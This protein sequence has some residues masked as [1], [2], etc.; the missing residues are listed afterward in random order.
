MSPFDPSTENQTQTS[1]TEKQCPRVVVV[2]ATRASGEQSGGK[3]RQE[4]GTVMERNP[5]GVK[6]CIKAQVH[7]VGQQKVSMEPHNVMDNHDG[8]LEYKNQTSFEKIQHYDLDRD[9]ADGSDYT[10][11]INHGRK[12]WERQ[13]DDRKGGGEGK[14]FEVLTGQHTC[15]S[16]PQI[17]ACAHFHHL[18]GSDLH[19]TIGKGISNMAFTVCLTSAPWACTSHS[20][21][22]HVAALLCPSVE[23]GTALICCNPN[24]ILVQCGITTIDQCLSAERT[25]HW[26]NAKLEDKLAKDMKHLHEKRWFPKY[27]II[28]QRL[29]EGS[30]THDAL[31]ATQDLGPGHCQ[32]P[33]DS[34]SLLLL[35]G[36]NFQND[37]MAAECP[38]YGELE[39]KEFW[40]GSGSFK[41][42]VPVIL[43]D[44]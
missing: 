33:E 27:D 22:A 43:M 20:I 34:V 16:S 5:Q 26:L 2:P 31:N 39:G 42:G 8:P 14:I 21:S 13:Q 1:E 24:R 15:R 29:S 25:V 12:P 3:D 7:I 40:G 28:T 11:I 6:L 10:V 23:P 19:R 4:I 36:A 37:F 32:P 35:P 30:V 44:V 9:G 18:D 38:N 41:A 17:S